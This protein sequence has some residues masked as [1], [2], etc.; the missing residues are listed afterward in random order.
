MP[1]LLEA[2]VRVCGVCPLR[3]ITSFLA[4]TNR[5]CGCA[6]HHP[7]FA[8]SAG[9]LPQ[10]FCWCHRGE[11]R[12]GGGQVRRIGVDAQRGQKRGAPASTVWGFT[13]GMYCSVSLRAGGRNCPGS[14]VV[15]QSR[16]T[17]SKR[18]AAWFGV[19][20]A[21]AG[22]RHP[23]RSGFVLVACRRCQIM[24]P[25]T[26]AVM[27]RWRPAGGRPNREDRAK[28]RCWSLSP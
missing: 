16:S 8:P 15:K 2:F 19:R 7:A 21:G 5:R 17:E 6:I 24:Y 1:A 22:H 14:A 23:P 18:I 10:L 28:F 11:V 20:C 26:H 3:K 27:P 12:T 13:T 25:T 9:S 4:H